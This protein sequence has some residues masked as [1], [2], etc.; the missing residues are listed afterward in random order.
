MPKLIISVVTWNSADSIKACIESI[1]NQSYSDYILYIVDNA[2]ADDTFSIVKS[3]TDVRIKAIKLESNTGFCGGHNHVLSQTQSDFVLLVNP[4]IILSSDYI[5]KA[6]HTITKSEHIGTVCGLLL[7]SAA[8]DPECRIDSAG[9]NMMPSR[10][11]GLRYH[12]EKLSDVSLAEAEVFGADGALPLYRRAMITY[13]SING[14]FFDEM[15]FA[16][17]EDWDVSW[18]SAIYGWKTI[19]DPACIAVHPRVFKPGNLK[20]RKNMSTQI[21]ID[22]V[23]NQLILLLKNE[24]GKRFILNFFHIVPRQL[25]IFFYILFFE[26]TSLK[27]YR[28][29]F[30]NRKQ[31]L[32]SR[33]IIQRNRKADIR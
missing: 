7:Q 18:R 32:A 23:K 22:A 30:R 3:I 20:L 26:R 21:K 33:K 28:F 15:F 12:G 25:M 9:L 19:F 31:I 16:H 13:I 1:L 14:Q 10:I 27:A 24:S 5:E 2:S 11:M 8:T 6:M 17:K 4:D 29:F